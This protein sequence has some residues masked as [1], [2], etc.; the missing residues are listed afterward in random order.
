MSA[1]GRDG[2]MKGMMRRGGGWKSKAGTGD[3][4]S[5]KPRTEAGEEGKYKR[6]M[7]GGEMGEHR[8]RNLLF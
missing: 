5:E 3:G 8:I 1:I 6:D 7:S 2:W 4:K